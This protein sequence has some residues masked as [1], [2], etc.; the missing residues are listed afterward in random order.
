MQCR[1]NLGSILIATGTLQAACIAYGAEVEK[2]YLP[3]GYLQNCDSVC[4]ILWRLKNKFLRVLGNFSIN[5]FFFYP[6]FG[7]LRVFWVLSP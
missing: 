5:V 2:G 4:Q 6:P 7:Y 1:L 3:H